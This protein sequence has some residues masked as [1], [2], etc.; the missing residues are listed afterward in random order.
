MKRKGKQLKKA[1][2]VDAIYLSITNILE[3][4][5]NTAYRAV[6]VA[7]VQ[8]YWQIGQII[9]EEEQ[10]GQKRAGYGKALIAELAHRLTKNYG[11]GFTQTNLWYMRQFYLSF[12][13]LHALRGE[14][15]WTHYRLLL[16][17]EKEEVR[18]FYM[19]ETLSNNWST[20]EL[21]RQII[22]LERKLLEKGSNSPTSRSSIRK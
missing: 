21:E 2:S 19:L 18:N 14:L 6:N 9:L 5:R 22:E 3:A 20:R 4:A 10:K 7:M 15:S 8:A 16:K 12:P 13:N 11:K 1:I 17:L